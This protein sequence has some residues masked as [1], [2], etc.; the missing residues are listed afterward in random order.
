MFL[1]LCRGHR[2]LLFSQMTRMLDILQ[3]YLEHRG[4][5]THFDCVRAF[6][7]TY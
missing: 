2:V 1:S 6:T 5:K 4:I 7:F 3:D